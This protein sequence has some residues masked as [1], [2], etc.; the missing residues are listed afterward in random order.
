LSI[1]VYVDIHWARSF[2]LGRIS[3]FKGAILFWE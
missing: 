1:L 3:F 2:E